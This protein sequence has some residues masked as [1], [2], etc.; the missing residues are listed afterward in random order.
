MRVEVKPEL[1]VW[2]CERTGNDV[3]AF[4][5]KFPKIESWVNGEAKPTFK[6][7]EALAKATHTPF[8]YL[9]LKEPPVE[10]VP[11]PDLRTVGNE[12]IGR[13]SPDLLDTIYLCQQR[14]DWYREYAR[15]EGQDP[16]PFVGSV[17]IND[18]IKV[19]ASQI[20]DALN[21]QVEV[22]AKMPTWT[23]AL[24]YFI[25]QAE[26]AGILVMCSG[27]VSNNT[28]RKLE[29]EE[30]RGFAI[31]DTMAPLVFVNG[32]DTKS[33]QMFTLAHELVHIWLGDSGLSDTQAYPET[34]IEVEIWCNQV[35][36]ELLVPLDVFN[37]DYQKNTGLEDE[38][39]RL[40]RRFKVSTLVILRRMHDAG[41]LTQKQFWGEY[42]RELKKLMAISK[43]SGGNFY[44]SQAARVSKRFARAVIVS[45]W[46][47]RSSFTE[48][49]R[50][51]G[52]KKMDTFKNLG[53]SLEVPI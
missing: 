7:L 53:A 24:R 52:C 48:A 45:T 42:N 14:Q 33:A 35:A 18:D 49:F 4:A 19:T 16:L 44:L 21:F 37:K 25:E 36:A 1:L 38:L 50:L 10:S 6:Q 51:V 46:E 32:A 41:G 13:P 11:I 2:A 26:S 9:F 23:D 8:G 31:A 12:H 22:R 39:K 3:G 47:G 27:I 34:K 20:R 17:K 15:A 28:H 43:G 40:A 5:K 29:P 30:F